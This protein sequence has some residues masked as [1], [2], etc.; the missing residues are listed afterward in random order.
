[1]LTFIEL[2]GGSF[3]LVHILD[4]FP[5]GPFSSKGIADRIRPSRLLEFI[6]DL[7]AVSRLGIYPSHGL[8]TDKKSVQVRI[9]FQPTSQ[10]PARPNDIIK[11]QWL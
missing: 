10:H 3:E 7:T 5:I 1:M 2:L 9:P 6:Q 8:D 4:R 11:E